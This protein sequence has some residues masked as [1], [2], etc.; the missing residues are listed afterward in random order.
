MSAAKQS[1]PYEQ[2]F[3][4]VSDAILV[5]SS[6]KITFCNNTLP[7]WLGYTPTE[8]LQEKFSRLIS[9]EDRN[10]ILDIL[11]LEQKPASQQEAFSLLSKDQ[12]CKISV[13]ANIRYISAG[14]WRNHTILTL[15]NTTSEKMTQNLLNSS[16]QN[17]QEIIETFPD[18]YYITDAKGVLVK[19]SPSVKLILGYEPSEVLGTPMLKY[20]KD[21]S[22][23]DLLM[24]Q[25]AAGK[26]Q[27]VRV[28]AHLLHKSG[29]PVWFNTRARFL[30]D[31]DGNIKG[32]EG[33]ARD[34]TIEQQSKELLYQR[35]Q[36]LLEIKKNLELKVQQQ[37]TELLNKE[38]LWLQKSRHEQMGEMISAIAHQW[39]QPLNV[40]SL[41]IN[42]L[43]LQTKDYP[44]TDEDIAL[45]SEKAHELIQSM[46][47]TIDEFRSFFKPLTKADVFNLQEAVTGALKLI[48]SNLSH[49]EI[50]CD[51]SNIDIIL[52]HGFANEFGQV[53]INLL[54]N[55]KESCLEK[56]IADPRIDIKLEVCDNLAIIEISDNA[57]GIS[58]EN[59]GKIFDPYFTTKEKG[60][61]IGL[62]M[63]KNIIE[64]H[65]Q[66]QIAVSNSLNGATFKITLPISQFGKQK[67]LT[68]QTEPVTPPKIALDSVLD[69]LNLNQF[70]ILYVDDN[71][72]SRFIFSR[73]LHKK[74][75]E[76]RVADSVTECFKI[77]HDFR[78]HLL[79]SDI[80]MPLEDGYSLI[81][82]IRTDK[83]SLVR[84]IPAIALSAHVD[85]EEIRLALHLGFQKYLTKP[86]NWKLLIKMITDLVPASDRI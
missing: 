23:R 12:K 44:C 81:K 9:E 79:I 22:L 54:T 29:R 66:G 50:N 20:Y 42:D 70:R 62:Y 74:G 83:N 43:T 86:V 51:F 46:S 39:R 65:M 25:I 3:E 24:A 68:A 13:L 71:Q 10:K 18:I 1:C 53:I 4:L 47:Q 84:N 41:W 32:L 14:E 27:Y 67:T 19:V 7:I 61:G 82:K 28:E 16:Q 35:E 55:A 30:Y 37:T 78:P 80:Q 5:L 63:S 11:K 73:V 36:E 38:R 6:D 72:E 58:T 59:L 85:E 26:G 31:S 17:L 33:L 52:V 76:V 49:I 69:D 77:L 8:L 40:L 56:N 57:E 64:R 75:A 15:K 21:P 2:V 60:T 34:S 48:S 45:F